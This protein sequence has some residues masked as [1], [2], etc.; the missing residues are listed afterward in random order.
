[1]SPKLYA[2]TQWKLNNSNCHIEE[3]RFL[4]NGVETIHDLKMAAWL[5]DRNVK[6]VMKQSQYAEVV[7]VPDKSVSGP[8]PTEIREI[9]NLAPILK[10][11]WKAT[12]LKSTIV[13]AWFGRFQR[14][15][16][17]RYPYRWPPRMEIW[18]I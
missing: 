12:F 2:H 9:D 5:V 4:L 13:L 6:S 1:M 15:P 11:S 7:F 17:R 3:L 16:L 18:P 10:V 8:L 14:T